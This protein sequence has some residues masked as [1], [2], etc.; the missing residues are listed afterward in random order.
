MGEEGEEKVRIFL[1]FIK[2]LLTSIKLQDISE[3]NRRHLAAA[4][5]I[6]HP[7]YPFKTHGY[8][9]TCTATYIEPKT[10]L[11]FTLPQF[12]LH[13]VVMSPDDGRKF[14]LKHVTYVRNN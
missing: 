9:V 10:L 13:I 3:A 6:P 14:R 1:V 8:Q 2:H 11:L 7:M 12:Y 5:N 4:R